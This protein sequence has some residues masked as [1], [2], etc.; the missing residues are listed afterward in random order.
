MNKD[1]YLECLRNNLRNIPEDE[2]NNI[3][4]YYREYF[5]EAGVENEQIV[6]NELGRP[7]LLANKV[8]ADYVIRDNEKS[9]ANVNNINNITQVKKGL[10]SIWVIILAICGFP[11]WFP[12]VIIIAAI[13]FSLVVAVFSVLFSFGI[14]AIAV[15]GSG[16]LAF[17]FGIIIL[18]MHIPTG[19][20][21]LGTACVA[22]G[23]GFLFLVATLWISY[24]FKKLIFMIGRVRTRKGVK[25]N[26]ENN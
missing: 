20:A 18:F 9:S 19:I 7:E 23:L 1:Q 3:I 6:I 10:S 21:T 13:V 15:I 22:I 16:L 8:S 14:A 26:V 4:E 25:N 24:F 2:M 11:I 5:E 12:M 17:I